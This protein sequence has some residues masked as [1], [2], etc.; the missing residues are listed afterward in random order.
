MVEVKFK[1]TTTEV[2]AWEKESQQSGGQTG[3]KESVVGEEGEKG[4]EKPIP[5]LREK[6]EGGDI[7]FSVV[8]NCRSA[9]C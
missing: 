2:G 7:K 6:D 4:A 5:V 3:A 9:S 1:W 8:D